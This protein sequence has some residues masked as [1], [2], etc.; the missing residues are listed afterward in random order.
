MLGATARQDEKKS[1]DQK[2]WNYSS[3]YLFSGEML[4]IAI[5]AGIHL[6]NVIVKGN[7]K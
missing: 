1:N 2:D 7:A 5:N 3:F 6:A 4:F